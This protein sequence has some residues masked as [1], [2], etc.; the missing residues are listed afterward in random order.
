MPTREANAEQAAGVCDDEPVPVLVAE[1]LPA[2]RMKYADGLKRMQ[3]KAL[4]LN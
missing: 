2:F 1:Q 4:N 3:G